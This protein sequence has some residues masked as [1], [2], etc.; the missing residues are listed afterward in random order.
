MVKGKVKYFNE[1]NGWGIIGEQESD[2]DVY[3]HYTAIVMDGY[4]TLREGQEVTFEL[5]RSDHG[6][7]AQNVTLS[8]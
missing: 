3:V 6:P 2:Q 4:R 7:A 5:T 8:G 1:R